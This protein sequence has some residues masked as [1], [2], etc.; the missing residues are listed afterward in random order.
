MSK[1]KFSQNLRL[2]IWIAHNRKSGY[3]NTP[4]SFNEMEIDHI[5]PERV[6]LNPKEKK[7]I[8][9][10]KEKYN[11]DDNFDIHGI[12]NLCP[13]T[14]EFNL[15]KYDHGLYDEGN[16][17]DSYIN[18]ALI[19]AKQLAPRIEEFRKKFKKQSDLRNA[20]K[21][22]KIKEEV[23]KGN[24]DLKTLI[25]SGLRVDYD[26]I[27]ELEELKKYERILRKYK[28]QGLKL[29]NFGEFFELESAI[30]YSAISK[31]EDINFWIKIFRDFLTYVED[32]KLKN[33]IFYEILYALFKTNQ[34][35]KEDEIALLEYFRSMESEFNTKIL[36]Q[37]SI[38]FNLFYG[39][40]QRGRVNT[41]I[42]TIF[43]LR[44]FLLNNLTKNVRNSK[45]EMRKANLEFSLLLLQTSY[46]PEEYKLILDGYEKGEILFFKR[47]FDNLNR[48]IDII[49]S[50]KF[51]D[52]NELYT[53]V[54]GF[55]ERVPI[56]KELPPYDEVLSKV[57]NL[58]NNYEGNNSTISDL[59]KRGIELYE[60]N[61]Y[62]QAIKQFQT[63]KNRSFN[64][65][66][67]YTCISSI[68]YIGECYNKLGLFYAAKYYFMVVFNLANELDV[69]YNVKQLTYSCGTDRIAMLGYNLKNPIEALYFTS[70]SMILRDFYLLEEIEDKIAKSNFSIL[71]TNGL[72][73]FAYTEQKSEFLKEKIKDFFEFLGLLEVMEEG[74]AK[75]NFSFSKEVIKKHDEKSGFMFKEETKNPREYNWP[76]LGINWT[77]KWENNIISTGLSEEFIAYTQIFLTTLEE[78]DVISPRDIKLY[79]KPS[80]ELNLKELDDEMIIFMPTL[81]VED[82]FHL[83]FAILFTLIS[84]YVIISRE[85]VMEEV[86]DLFE[87]GYF[88]NYY[89]DIYKKLLPSDLFDLYQSLMYDDNDKVE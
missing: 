51:F 73:C 53:T 48:L 47:Y 28:S 10:W 12:E 23:E 43:E 42:K 59:M 44:E 68:Y 66:K 16:A 6:L 30:R 9:K 20:L 58:K 72:T 24:L 13:S 87:T 52:F 62:L 15:S 34:S 2:A 25:L 33:N 76:Q 79:L 29:L 35:W 22:A 84:K 4:I 82:F 55:A 45:N 8:E 36:K 3:D 31:K 5:I 65:E 78:I 74:T 32:S 89:L 18:K 50:V 61:K 75:L 38:L 77:V 37:S 14:R 11:L 85:Q 88:S 57:A 41:S 60:S 86:K 67:V 21:I 63:V 71:L 46:S 7:E 1:Q 19:K 80:D 70:I 39:E 56:I 69:E 17:F 49:E 26:E 81:K 83:F 40:F 64:P 54:T 27:K